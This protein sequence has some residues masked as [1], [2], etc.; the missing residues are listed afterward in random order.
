MVGVKC[1]RACY[2]E[3][4]IEIQIMRIMSTVSNQFCRRRFHFLA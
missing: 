1:I 3:N 2:F 4:K